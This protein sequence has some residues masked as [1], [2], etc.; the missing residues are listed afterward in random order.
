MCVIVDTNC[1]AS[2]FERKSEKHPQFAPVLEWIISG[3]TLRQLHRS[4]RMSEAIKN[5]IGA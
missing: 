3:T 5:A 2:V 4:Y 1:L